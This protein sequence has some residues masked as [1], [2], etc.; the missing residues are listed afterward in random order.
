M[1]G[2]P[3]KEVRE[4]YANKELDI[5]MRDLMYCFVATKQLNFWEQYKLLIDLRES[6]ING[7]FNNK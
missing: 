7:E 1:N 5:Y 4:K 6:I 3:N 2:E